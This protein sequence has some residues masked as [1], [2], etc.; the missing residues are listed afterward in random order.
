MQS[1]M[2]AALQ[3]RLE[4]EKKRRDEFYDLANRYVSQARRCAAL[5]RRKATRC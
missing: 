2:R 4:P 1:L 5:L 3:G